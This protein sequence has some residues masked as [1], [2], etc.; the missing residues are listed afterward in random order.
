MSFLKLIWAI[1]PLSAFGL[2]SLDSLDKGIYP[3]GK[4][5]SFHRICETVTKGLKMK[6]IRAQTARYGWNL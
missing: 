4:D 1:L 5:K 2:Y 6:E 3:L